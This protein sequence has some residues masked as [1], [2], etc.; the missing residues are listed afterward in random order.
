MNRQLDIA[1]AEGLGYDIHYNYGDH[2]GEHRYRKGHRSYM[3]PYYCADGAAMVELMSAMWLQGYKFYF[4]SGV[5]NT[6]LFVK[7]DC[8]SEVDDIT[9]MGSFSLSPTYAVA[10]AAY[11]AL[12]GE[13]WKDDE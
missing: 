4:V 7:H 10:L 5:L 9:K 13:E 1:I 8:V 3:I 11:K 6:A 2:I 12:T